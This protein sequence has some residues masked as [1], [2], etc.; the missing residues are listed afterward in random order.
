MRSDLSLL[1][2][3]PHQ[4]DLNAGA[5]CLAFINSTD[6]PGGFSQHDDL[7]PGYANVLSW[8]REAGIVDDESARRLLALARRNPREAST[9]RR[10]IIEFRSALY[11]L[12]MASINEPSPAPDDLALFKQELA[13]TYAQ[14]RIAIAD[15]STRYI[16]IWDEESRLDSILR[17]IVRSAEDVLFSDR[18]DR[19]RQCAGEDCH[20]I[21]LDTSK[22]RSR[23]YCSTTGCGNRERVRRFRQDGGD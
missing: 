9:V 6:N 21:F 23:R 8:A 12:V 22:N 7:Q 11:R 14:A 20:K 5:P 2:P 10:R 19:L 15:D 16:W 18:I 1:L 3:R 13:E 17:E 4:V